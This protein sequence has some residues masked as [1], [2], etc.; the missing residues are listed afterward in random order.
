MWNVGYL[1]KDW[2]EGCLP[3]QG[4]QRV[5]KSGPESREQRTRK[6]KQ[7]KLLKKNFLLYLTIILNTYV[8]ISSIL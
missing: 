8:V 3:G 7:A 5:R 6:L 2:Q 4:E 1:D